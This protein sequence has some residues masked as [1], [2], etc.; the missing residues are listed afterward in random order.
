MRAKLVLDLNHGVPGPC[1]PILQF[2]VMHEHHVDTV[3]TFNYH[4]RLQT[5]TAVCR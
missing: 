4:I 5:R 2:W 1:M 3:S